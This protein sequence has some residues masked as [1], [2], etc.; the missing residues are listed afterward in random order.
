VSAT[1]HL[2]DIHWRATGAGLGAV[3][4]DVHYLHW[5]SLRREWGVQYSVLLDDDTEVDL[6]QADGRWKLCYST[7]AET[8][9]RS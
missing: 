7:S 3:V 4:K 6:V 9:G 1:G 5:T 2:P 8:I